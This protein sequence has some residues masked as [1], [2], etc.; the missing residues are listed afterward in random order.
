MQLYGHFEVVTIYALHV[1]NVYNMFIKVITKRY[2]SV[3]RDTTYI[4]GKVALL[5]KAKERALRLLS[6]AVEVFRQAELRNGEALQLTMEDEQSSPSVT[7]SASD[8]D[9]DSLFSGES[10]ED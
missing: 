2:Q 4:Q 5:Y 6:S 3:S 10:D 7:P 9:D 8:V 1:H